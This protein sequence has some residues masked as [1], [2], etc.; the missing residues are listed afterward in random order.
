MAA[1]ESQ[2]LVRAGRYG[3]THCFAGV[4]TKERHVA[5]LALR[6]CLQD[7]EWSWTQSHFVC[8]DNVFA[9]CV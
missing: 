1:V 7:R 6:T 8:S 4:G 5:V 3:Y 2:N 9:E